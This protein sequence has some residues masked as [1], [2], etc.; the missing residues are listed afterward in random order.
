LIEIAGNSNYVISNEI[1]LG[2]V[3]S[4]TDIA[5][6]SNVHLLNF[7]DVASWGI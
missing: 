7:F 1:F 3:A 5:N 4:S 6:Q 2:K